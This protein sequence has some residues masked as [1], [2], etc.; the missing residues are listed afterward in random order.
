MCRRGGCFWRN[1]KEF[2]MC[3]HCIHKAGEGKGYKCD[4]ILYVLLVSLSSGAA[5]VVTEQT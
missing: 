2:K 1:E 3:P 4:Q 5:F